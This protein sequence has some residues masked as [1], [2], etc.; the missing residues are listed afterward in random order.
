MYNK[1]Y[2]ATKTNHAKNKKTM[3]HKTNAEVIRNNHAKMDA[4]NSANKTTIHTIMQRPMQQNND[5]NTYAIKH[6]ANKT[7]I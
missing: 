2:D 1:N 7:R 5:A 3:M 6:D 4:N